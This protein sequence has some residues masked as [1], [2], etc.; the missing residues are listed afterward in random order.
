MFLLTIII[1]IW[2]NVTVIKCNKVDCFPDI[3]FMIIK[4]I[5]ITVKK[6]SGHT[7]YF[8]TQYNTMTCFIGVNSI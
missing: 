3:I 8:V 4:H 6:S 2:S 1:T 5:L 7:L